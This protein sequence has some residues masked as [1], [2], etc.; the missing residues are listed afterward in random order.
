MIK[1]YGGPPLWSY[2]PIGNA[3]Y[4]EQQAEKNTAKY[5]E[6]KSKADQK[7]AE[8]KTAEKEARDRH[9]QYMADLERRKVE[10]ASREQQADLA[11]KFEKETRENIGMGSDALDVLHDQQAQLSQEQLDTVTQNIDT[12]QQGGVEDL[13]IPWTAIG[14]L[15]VASLGVWYWRK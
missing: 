9:A 7:A 5:K 15:G 11:R 2:L 6:D 8:Q 4:R 12:V 14:L 13:K 1:S 3:I 10:Q